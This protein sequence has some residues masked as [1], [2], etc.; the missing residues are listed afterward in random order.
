M[1][2][3][4]TQ[5][6]RQALATLQLAAQQHHAEVGEH[7]ERGAQAVE[8]AEV[9]AA[10]TVARH[11]AEQAHAQAQDQRAGGVADGETDVLH[12]QVVEL[13]Q[14]L[15][16]VFTAGQGHFLEYVGMAANRALAEDHQVAR[17]D[18][19][20]LDGDE[21]RRTL[22]GTT[23]VVARAHDDALAAV[24]VHGVG[25][26]FAAALG[27]VVLEDRR[28]HRRLLAQVHRV[29][30]EDARAVHQPGIAADTR[31]GFLNAF[32]GRQR[33]IELF[34]YLAVLA[35]DQ[36]GELGGAGAHRR[37]GNRTAYRQAVHQ[38]HPALAQVLGAADQVVQ[39]DEHILA[40]VG[41]VHEGGA[42]RYVATADVHAGGVGGNQR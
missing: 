23:Q 1:A 36:A 6:R 21:D 12:Q 41:A 22:P 18:V 8:G 13:Q 35:G 14:R 5:T 37:Q 34:T 40:G 17:E 20:A 15:V 2:E 25:D 39:R 31:Q 9:G 16:T 11:L 3:H 28:Q 33:H 42:Q 7:G 19:G 38:H 32:E 26:A 4:V 10:D 29:G 27:E 30:G 24:H